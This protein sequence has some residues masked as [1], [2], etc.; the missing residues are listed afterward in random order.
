MIDANLP[1][2]KQTN[3]ELLSIPAKIKKASSTI[4]LERKKKNH[5]RSLSKTQTNKR[6]RII[7]EEVLMQ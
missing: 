4:P 1:K 3:K 5:I 6:V 7:I 2:L